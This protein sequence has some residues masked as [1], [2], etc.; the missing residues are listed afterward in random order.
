MKKSVI[1]AI[2]VVYIVAIVTV[3]F[4]GA[5]MRV[6][7][8]IVRI[9]SISC[10]LVADDVTN[11]S[12]KDS[13]D[14]DYQNLYKATGKDH[15]DYVVNRSFEDGL[16]V[17]LR[18]E[19]QPGNATDKTLKFLC[20]EKPNLYTFTDNGDGSCQFT[21]KEATMVSLRV[22][23]EDKAVSNVEFVVLLNVYEK[24]F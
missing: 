24:L 7:D 5:K 22:K 11:I 17:Y 15:V 10:A 18:F 1:L 20:D 14:P 2:F 19:V 21:F 13:K 9:E 3:G 12:T 8:E 4:Y 16:V 6:Y 23:P